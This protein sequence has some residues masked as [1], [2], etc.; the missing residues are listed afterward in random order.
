MI[1]RID[2]SLSMGKL[3]SKK[4]SYFM[5]FCIFFSL[6]L[7]ILTIILLFI[8][9]EWNSTE[10]FALVVASV[11]FLSLF[12]VYLYIYLKDK[13]IKKRVALYLEDAVE[14][15]GYSK[16]I[17]EFRAGIQ[18]KATKIEVRF[19]FDNRKITKE[20]TATVFGSKKGCI[21]TFNKYAD[22]KVKILYSPTFGEVFILKDK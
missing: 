21:G 10:F 8:P 22:R 13:N 4:E 18:P 6:T 20:S 1:E 12:A 2:C 15:D 16:K 11:M 19:N 7:P 3:L 14:L 5:L 9:T 17:G